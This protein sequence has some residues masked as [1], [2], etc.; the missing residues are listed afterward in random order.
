MFLQNRPY[1][2]GVG[3]DNGLV[4]R[5]EV[6]DEVGGRRVDGRILDHKKMFSLDFT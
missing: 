3:D 5:Q 4:V 2:V 1:Q 6:G